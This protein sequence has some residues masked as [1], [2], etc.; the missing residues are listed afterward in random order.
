MCSTVYSSRACLADAIKGKMPW[1]VPRVERR[2]GG[3]A[4]SCRRC[5]SFCTYYDDESM[6]L[7]GLFA[8]I[9]IAVTWSSGVEVELLV[10][11]GSSAT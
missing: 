9:A 2:M 6:P 10:V 11:D 8:R 3:C 1:M 7:K 5:A 4:S